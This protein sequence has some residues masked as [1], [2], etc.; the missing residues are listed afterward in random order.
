MGMANKMNGADKGTLA[1]GTN[2]QMLGGLLSQVG[3]QMNEYVNH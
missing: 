2:K 1:G 3:Y